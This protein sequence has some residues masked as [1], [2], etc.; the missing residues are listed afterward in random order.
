MEGVSSDYAQDPASGIDYTCSWLSIL[1]IALNNN[2]NIT[3]SIIDVNGAVVESNSLMLQIQ[4]P[5]DAPRNFSVVMSNTSST[6]FLLFWGAPFT[7]PNT[8]SLPNIH[9][10]IL[11][12]NI[13]IYGCRTILSKPNC[14]FPRNC[15]SDIDFAE[16]GPNGEHTLAGTAGYGGPIGFSFSTVNGAGNAI[17]VF[18]KSK[19]NIQTNDLPAG[20]TAST[21]V[22]SAE[23]MTSSL[24]TTFICVLMT[25]EEL[26]RHLI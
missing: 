26:P 6:I 15:I 20:A 1:P 22:S 3:C 11:C 21:S 25:F 4:G 13:T 7:L 8:D 17:F 9:N 24:I 5:L 18:T 10:Y 12:T 14:T 19:E 23:H 2:T 16:P